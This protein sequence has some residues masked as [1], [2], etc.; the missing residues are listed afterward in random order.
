MNG[1]VIQS[2]QQPW[3][4]EHL[5][6]LLNVVVGAAIGFAAAQAKD[7]LEARRAKKAFMVAVKRELSAIQDQLARAHDAI[8]DAQ[9]RFDQSGT[10]PQFAVAFSTTAFDS[11][12][13]RLRSL[14]DDLVL[15]I[16]NFYSTLPVLC[17]MGRL[18]NEQGAEYLRAAGTADRDQAG[19]RVRSAL[20]VTIEEVE[21]YQCT[22]DSL[23]GKLASE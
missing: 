3:W 16:V 5:F 17:G 6:S 20:R 12:L 15:T 10:P 7:W 19:I 23:T 14:S 13:P 4:A 8:K 21:K 1:F 22:L 9:Q 2:S 11:Q 18:V